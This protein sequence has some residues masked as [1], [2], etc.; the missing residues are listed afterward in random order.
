MTSEE[1][2]LGVAFDG[3]GPD[4]LVWPREGDAMPDDHG[5]TDEPDTLDSLVMEARDRLTNLGFFAG[6]GIVWILVALVVTT[7]DPRLDPT[8]GYVGALLI[9]LAVGLTVVPLFW[10][11][12][13]ARHRR[14]AYRGD[15]TR[16]IRRGGWVAV[17]TA[18]FVILRLQQAFVPALAL[19]ILALVVL[20][21]A[22]LTVER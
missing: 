12:I 4:P 15:W 2:S 11:G 13:F 17:V 20:A 7:R 8:A 14:I 9:G 6:A 16:A 1:T 5:P 22:V 3:L 19:F 10:L 21:E 18:V